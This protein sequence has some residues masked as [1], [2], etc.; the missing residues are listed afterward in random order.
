MHYKRIA[1]GGASTY[2]G[3]TCRGAYI[4][5]GDSCR[6]SVHYERIAAGGAYTYEEG[7]SRLNTG[8]SVELYVHT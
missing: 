1:A 5:E 6:W 8:G 4:N 2:E 3:D 7:G